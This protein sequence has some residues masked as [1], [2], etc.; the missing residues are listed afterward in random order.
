[1]LNNFIAHQTIFNHE[2][3]HMCLHT[4]QVQTQRTHWMLFRGMYCIFGKD[5]DPLW[6]PDQYSNDRYG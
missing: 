3:E 4:M 6:G 1:M 2:Y 5:P